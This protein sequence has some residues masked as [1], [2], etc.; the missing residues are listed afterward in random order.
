[1]GHR[2]EECPLLVGAVDVSSAAK[3]E[4]SV[5]IGGVWNIADIG[6][7]EASGPRTDSN[8]YGVLSDS[9][10]PDF[11]VVENVKSRGSWR[12]RRTSGASR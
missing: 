7:I 10:G 2:K 4:M 3:E 9:G 6:Q 11:E 8:R 1:M 5:E 12:T